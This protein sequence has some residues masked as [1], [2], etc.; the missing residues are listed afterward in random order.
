ME[1]MRRELMDRVIREVI[2]KRYL[3]SQTVYHINPCGAF[4]MGGPMAD[5]G[6]TGRKIIVVC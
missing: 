3:T 6:L 2:P 1:E 5:S 4:L